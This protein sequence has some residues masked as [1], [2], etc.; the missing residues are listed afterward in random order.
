MK[1]AVFPGSFDPIT[2]G[3]LD[4]LKR[5]IP[6]FDKIIVLVAINESKKE[7]FTLEERTQMIKEATKEFNNVEVDFYD[8]LTVDYAK[9][10]GATYLIRGIRNTSDYDYELELYKANKSLNNSIETVFFMASD[11]YSLISSSK[12][13]ELKKNKVDISNLVPNSVI[14]MYK[15]KYNI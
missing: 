14:K 13:N 12:I 1:I 4:I 8:G 11:D 6:L 7:N 5:A 10:H 9:N 2:N 15:K 3:H